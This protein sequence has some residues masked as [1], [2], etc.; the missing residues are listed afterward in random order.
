VIR[1]DVHDRT[2][3]GSMPGSHNG[4]SDDTGLCLRKAS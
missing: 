4:R 1:L 3:V 2:I